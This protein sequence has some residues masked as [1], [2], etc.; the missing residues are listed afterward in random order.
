MLSIFYWSE[1]LHTRIG[2]KRFFHFSTEMYSTFDLMAL[3]FQLDLDILPLYLHVKIQ[4]CPFHLESETDTQT[5]SQ[6]KLLHRP[7]KR[8]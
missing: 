5:D 7:L 1:T 8:V 3:I 6:P 2:F 4:V